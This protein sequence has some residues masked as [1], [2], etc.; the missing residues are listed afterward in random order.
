MI[1]TVACASILLSSLI[2]K[3]AYENTKLTDYEKIQ[4]ILGGN[5]EKEENGLQLNRKTKHNWGTEYVFNFPLGKTFRDYESKKQALEDGLVKEVALTFDGWITLKVY[6]KEFPAQVHH[7]PNPSE[8]SFIAGID[9]DFSPKRINFEKIPH[10]IIGGGT[11]YGKSNMIHTIITS[12]LESK[13]DSVKFTLIDLKGGIELSEYENLKQTVKVAYEPF[14]AVEALD[15]VYRLMRAT[16]EQL[17]SKGHRKIQDSHIKERHFI[18]IDEVGELNP[19]EAVSKEEKA[20]KIEC[21]KY[22][23]Q[24]ARLGAG[25]GFRMILATQ[26]PTGDVIP[27]QCKQ[28]S[29]GKICFRVQ[30]GVASRV[31]LDEEGA[32]KLP[33]IKG[34][35]IMQAGT[36][37]TIIQTPLVR[38]DTIRELVSKN[39]KEE[40]VP[41]EQ[42]NFTGIE[43]PPGGNTF[44]IEETRL[45]D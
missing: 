38:Y 41:D 16:Q 14:E 24:I 42:E 15:V 30:S 17:R 22:L 36:N 19:S 44:I 5:G 12:L 32:E 4:I 28:N 7:E 9:R 33:D 18:I 25:L 13:P 37:K 23:S 11:R 10:L 45:S 8:W 43:Q 29:D 1:V 35:A 27:R 6:D 39:L 2:V 21:Q 20:L 3:T 31:V 26:Y 34:R 40:S